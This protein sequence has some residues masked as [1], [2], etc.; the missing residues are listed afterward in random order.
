MQDWNVYQVVLAVHRAGSLRGAA[1]LLNTTHTTVARR[2]EQ[3]ER[4]Q[5]AP[6]FER[7]V[8]GFSATALGHSFIQ[9][10]TKM[11]QLELSLQRTNAIQANALQGPI[12]LS[13]GEPLF[14]YFLMNPLS[15]FQK[16]HPDIQLTLHCTTAF[17]DLDNA[18]ADVIIR[19]T[20][21]P[22]PHLVG[23]RFAPYGLSFY[24]NPDYLSNT[25]QSELRWITRTGQGPRPEWLK[26]SPYP[27]APVFL[28]ID[29]IVGVFKSLE[30]GLGIGRAACFMADQSKQ[31]VRLEGAEVT[32]Q[33]EM[34]VLTHPDLRDLPRVK[35]LMQFLYETFEQN[36]GLISGTH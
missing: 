5:R 10:A 8:N 34:W 3:L 30:Q 26:S 22:P 15:E 9:V 33:S 4:K 25:P 21:T 35:A 36:A 20:N 31:L 6:L 29:D 13:L 24:G 23:R 28:Q 14:Q 11:E 27:N 18:E 17:V 1:K 12:T 32:P 7:L 19:S 2:L 16:A